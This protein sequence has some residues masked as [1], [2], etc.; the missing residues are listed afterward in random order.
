MASV[1]ASIV[2]GSHG[3]NPGRTSRLPSSHQAVLDQPRRG[4]IDA[5]VTGKCEEAGPQNSPRA[6]VHLSGARPFIK[7]MERLGTAGRDGGL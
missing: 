1:E 6:S 5:G 3:D 4:M 7:Q 2:A